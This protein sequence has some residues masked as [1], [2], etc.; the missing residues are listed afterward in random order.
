VAQPLNPGGAELS[1]S[2]QSRDP[3][4]IL[5]TF[6]SVY[7][8][9]KTVYAK[10]EVI[11]SALQEEA[12]FS[13]WG[14]FLVA[15]SQV[16]DLRLTIDRPLFTFTYTYEL[17]HQNTGIIVDTGKVKGASDGV[18]APKIARLIVQRIA[19]VRGWPAGVEPPKKD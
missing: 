14:L 6:R 16:A 12:A 13:A 19:T 9:S 1:G 18:V 8:L 15:D 10:P 3:V 17:A 2:I 5:R 4:Q 7:V 11:Q